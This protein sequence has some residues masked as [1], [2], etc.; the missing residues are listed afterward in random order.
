MAA[1]AKLERQRVWFKLLCLN[2]VMALTCAG[3]DLKLALGDNYFNPSL[4]LHQGTYYLAVRSMYFET[5]NSMRQWTNKAHL[6]ILDAFELTGAKCAEFDPWQGDFR[7]C[8]YSPRIVAKLRAETTGIEDLKLFHWPGKGLYGIFGRKPLSASPNNT[9]A[10][11]IFQQFMVKVSEDK[12]SDLSDP[13]N[14]QRPVSLTLK[15]P[16]GLYTR[17]LH[18]KEKNWMPFIYRDKLY[19][20]YSVQPHRVFEILSNGTAVMR[21]LTSSPQFFDNLTENLHSKLRGG[22][23]LVRVPSE[24]SIWKEDYYLGILHFTNY[25]DG[26]MWYRHHAF[27]VQS[28]PPFKLMGVSRELKLQFRQELP[29]DRSYA[30]LVT[31]VSGLHLQHDGTLVIG[32]GSADIEARLMIMPLQDLEHLFDGTLVDVNGTSANSLEQLKSL[33]IT[34]L[35]L[36]NDTFNT[37]AVS[38]PAPSRAVPLRY[39]F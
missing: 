7:E 11:T 34:L 10:F 4:V 1:R 18:V 15:P 30:Q 31:Y 21:Y 38:T 13:W 24:L 35:P 27:K 25:I 39:K 20:T 33:N 14:L 26:R 16:K 9:C 12:S 2:A 17:K 37:Q 23:P 28:R 19:V 29:Y 5:I 32:Y 22:P 8:T 3:R 36:G 6:C